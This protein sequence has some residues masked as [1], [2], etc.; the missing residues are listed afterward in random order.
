M[1]NPFEALE[2]R[3]CS[4][5]DQL[6]SLLKEEGNKRGARYRVGGI[7][8]AAEVTGLAKPTIY[9]L[10]ARRMIPFSKPTG[11]R[12]LRFS[13][14][15]LLAWIDAGNMATAEDITEKATLQLKK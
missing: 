6:E 8:L 13:E 11:T 14:E 2:K 5:I 12:N 4:R 7:D 15:R 9:K 1:E 10:V 3:I